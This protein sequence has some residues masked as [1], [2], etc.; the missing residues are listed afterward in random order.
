M[1]LDHW[2]SISFSVNPFELLFSVNHRAVFYCSMY[3]IVNEWK[4]RRFQS[5]IDYISGTT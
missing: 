5:S 4:S 1:D 3:V 2:L